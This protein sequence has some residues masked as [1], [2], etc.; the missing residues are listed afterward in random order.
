MRNRIDTN[1]WARL[2]A[3]LAAVGTVALWAM[4]VFGQEYYEAQPSNKHSTLIDINGKPIRDDAFANAIKS[5]MFKPF[6]AVQ[7][8]RNATFLFQQCY[9]GG[10]LD[11]LIGVFNR[12]PAI[13][14]VGG[15]ACKHNEVAYGQMTPKEACVGR[16]NGFTIVFNPGGFWT[17]ALWPELNK[18]NQ[19]V[20]TD[21]NNARALD[22]VGVSSKYKWETGQSVYRNNGQS[23]TLK[24]PSAGSHHAVLWGGYPNALR[25]YNNIAR[26]RAALINC[27]GALGG[28]PNSI[29]IL[30]TENSQT[31]NGLY[32]DKPLPGDWNPTLSTTDNLWYVLGNLG[33]SSLNSAETF[34]FYATDHGGLITS[35]IPHPGNEIQPGDTGTA[36]YEAQWGEVQG[37]Y[38]ETI[39]TPTV[40]CGYTGPI[41]PGAVEVRFNGLPLGSLIPGAPETVL[42]VP[43]ELIAYPNNEVQ[44]YNGG[45]TPVEVTKLE[46]FT[47]AI[48]PNPTLTPDG[49]KGCADGTRVGPAGAIV[50][51]V[52]PDYFYI[53]SLD[54]NCGIK[55]H[56]PGHGLSRGNAVDLLGVIMT[57]PANDERYI[58]ASTINAS[59]GDELAPV[60]MTNKSVGGGDWNYDPMLYSGQRGIAGASGLNNIGLL[61]RTWGRV[62]EAEPQSGSFTIDDGSGPGLQ[63]LVPEGAAPP[64]LQAYV[65]AT[66]ISSC[67]K[68][69][70][71]LHRLLKP[72]DAADIRPLAEQ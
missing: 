5:I 48:G 52:G 36:P 46:F 13:P 62:I 53:E 60:G 44:I 65:V 28:S 10:F 57:D 39:N 66:G 47:G 69:G 41:E 34:F 37:M 11:D 4:P 1:C 18:C 71:E 27:W 49:A 3:A 58:E 19:F 32:D 35:L 30:Y 16:T 61:V 2:I 59:Q 50:T 15:S 33:N 8:A 26:V 22:V 70:E 17:N 42:P 24:D 20:I 43:E 67:E 56:R 14:W 64:E 63:C 51:A 31:Q 7:N 38:L 21:V 12:T 9:G 23:F 25:Y 54:R 55:V 72:R 29:D 45:D 6:P 68:S 40:T